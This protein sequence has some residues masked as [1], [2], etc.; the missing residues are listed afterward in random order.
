[1]LPVDPEVAEICAAAMDE[2]R[3]LGASVTSAASPDFGDVRQIVLATRG[4]SMAMAHDDHIERTTASACRPGCVWNIDQGL[5]L[6]PAEIGAGIAAARALW[7]RVRAFMADHEL[8]ACP[9][10][11]VPPFPVEQPY[12]TEIA[13]VPL[14]DYTHWFFLTYAITLTGLPAIS[15]PCGFTAPACRSACSSSGAVAGRRTCC[16]PRPRWSGNW[17]STGARRAATTR[18]PETAPTGRDRRIPRQAAA[19]RRSERRCNEP[20]ARFLR[21]P[22]T[23]GAGCT[24]RRPRRRSPTTCRHRANAA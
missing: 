19:P 16:A 24:A 6:T 1:M 4:L 2:L 23:L 5:A 20:H 10:V 22:R 3:R 7:E 8:L 21:Q 12:P 9:T 17:R 14:A 15:I 18:R 11:A 13:G